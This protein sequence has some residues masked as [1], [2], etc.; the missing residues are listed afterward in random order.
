MR[1][2]QFLTFAAL[3]LGAAGCPGGGDC[4]QDWDCT[5]GEVCASTRECVSAG[6][7]R[8]V[9]VNW[10]LYG[11]PASSGNCVGVERMELTVRNAATDENATYAPVPCSVGR[12]VFDQLPYRFDAVAM[13]AFVGGLLAEAEQASIPGSGVVSLDFSVGSTVDAGVPVDAPP[14]DAGP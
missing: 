7:V 12:F 11:A 10:T 9:E 14:P 8:R 3:A 5:G 6:D 2:G 4:E 13:S 1:P